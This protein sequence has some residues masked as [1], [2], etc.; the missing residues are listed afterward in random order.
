MKH[1]RL[2]CEVATGIVLNT[3]GETRFQNH[4]GTTELPY[5]EAKSLEEA[6]YWAMDMLI[7][8]PGVEVTIYDEEKNY[9]NTI[10][11]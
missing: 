5:I 10:S 6:Q 9:I 2:L 7:M 8:Y 4:Y 1:Y 11:S 3:D